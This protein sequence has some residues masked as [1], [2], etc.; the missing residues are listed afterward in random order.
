MR[1]IFSTVFGPHEPAL[2]VGSFAISATG[3]PATRPDARHDP[4]GAE[5]VLLP[6]R[7]QRLLG[8]RALVE[9][10]RDALAHRE[11]ALLARLLVVALGAARRARARWRRSARSRARQPAIPVARATTA[12][13]MTFVAR[14]QP[15]FDHIEV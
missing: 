9:Q 11:L 2:T 13:E 4:V 5:A 1:R 6:V 3:R 12:S 8:E 15:R 7:Q 14:L 10:Q